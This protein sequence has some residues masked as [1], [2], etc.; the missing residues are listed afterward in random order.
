[1]VEKA[2]TRTG[3]LRAVAWLIFGLAFALCVSEAQL[4]RRQTV[5]L[6]LLSATAATA[7]AILSGSYS[8]A[9]CKKTLFW[10]IDRTFH[11]IK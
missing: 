7:A 9:G 2:K 3:V 10:S 1:M 6:L 8:V 4:V 5:V 11:C